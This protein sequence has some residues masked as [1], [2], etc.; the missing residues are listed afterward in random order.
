MLSKI[1]KENKY[2]NECENEY[3]EV[4]EIKKKY[5]LT[6]E[7]Y[8]AAKTWCDLS[9][10]PLPEKLIREAA[11]KVSWNFVSVRSRLSEEFIEKFQDKVSWLYI[12]AYQLLSEDF[13]REFKNE[14]NWSYIS[15]YQPLSEDFIREFKN[16]VNWTYIST[17]QKLSENFIREFKDEVDWE[18]ISGCQKLSEGFIREFQDYVNWYNISEYQPLSEEFIRE[19]QDEV[20][21]YNISWYQAVSKEFLA[22]FRYELCNNSDK[23]VSYW[24]R[25]VQETGL[26]ECHRDYFYA[27]KGIRSDRYSKYNFQYRYMPGETYECFSDY[28][29]DEDSFGLSAWT[30]ECAEG[31]CN[32]L[33]VKVKI[34]YRD[35]T[36]VVHDGGK[37]RCK[38]LT[39]ME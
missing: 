6:G 24:K 23:P 27:Y 29:D 12:S 26:Y 4:K 38:K 7:K 35:V 18:C 36:A 33:V 10:L 19:F 3:E 13:I 31:Y 34:Y 22:E 15:A 1:I 21:W 8:D 11:D 30:E 14:V 20:D 2:M 5:N 9:F 28:S 16:E 39:V 37:I 32:E 25:E 17:Y